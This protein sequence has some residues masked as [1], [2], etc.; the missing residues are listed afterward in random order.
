MLELSSL[1]GLVLALVAIGLG[2]VLKGASL[3]VLVNPAAFLIIIAGTL[4]TL[5]VAF[6]LSQM[7]QFPKLLM[8]AILG[9]RFSSR[10]ELIGQLVDFT[11]TVRR[12]GLLSLDRLAETVKD[13]FLKKALILATSTNE[14][15][16]LERILEAE[17]DSLRERHHLGASMF[18]QS[19]TYAPTLGVLG[20]V[21]GLIAALGNLSDIE[22]LGHSIAAA[23]VATLLGIF[24]GYVVWHPLANKM[25]ALSRLEQANMELILLGVLCMHRGERAII[26]EQ[27]LLA[28]LSS[29]E[30]AKYE[31]MRGKASNGKEKAAA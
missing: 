12:D 4:A 7:K 28:Q 19:G 15:E 24:T 2:M 18:S 31:K 22:K 26:A 20:A 1:I 21:V 16:S 13:P 30:V 27:E 8:I 17:I 25:K 6:P 29:A 9:R 11:G 14:S 23:F 5:F 10:I 3:Q